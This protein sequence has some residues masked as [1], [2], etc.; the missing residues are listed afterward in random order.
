MKILY[1]G[2]IVSSAGIETVRE[3]LPQLI[4]R[5]GID[6]VVAQSENVSGGRGMTLADMRVLQ[7]MGVD[8]FTGGNWS[9]YQEELLPLLKDHSQPVCGPANYLPQAK[10]GYKYVRLKGG[11]KIMVVSLLGQIISRQAEGTTDPLQ[12]IE[13]I[14]AAREADVAATVVNFHG[15]FSSEKRMIGYFL[16]GR[17]SLVV[18]DHW[19]VPTADEIVLPAG[20]AHV[21]DVGMCGSLHSSLGVSL[22]VSLNR[23]RTKQPAKNVWDDSRPWQFNAVLAEINPSGLGGA[24][25]PYSRKPWPKFL[26]CR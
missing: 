1:L 25:Q 21:T 5:H 20:T 23:W 2:D 10:P 26:F 6:G 18:G 13:E 11:A 17:A 19:H 3:V 7:N 14:L 22:E 15:D 12:R 16:D 8:A 4:E 24:D 9:L